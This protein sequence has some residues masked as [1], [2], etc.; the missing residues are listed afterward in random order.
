ME[1]YHI[2]PVLVWLGVLLV[3]SLLSAIIT[4]VT[5][6]QTQ[7]DRIVSRVPRTIPYRFPIL[8]ST[9]PFL[10]DGLNLFSYAS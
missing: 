7:E 5:P 6:S 10:F 2:H 9:V 8:K 3:L 1:T 4:R